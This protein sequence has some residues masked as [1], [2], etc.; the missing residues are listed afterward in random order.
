VLLSLEERERLAGDLL[1]LL[2]GEEVAA[3][4]DGL[5]ADV[6]GV[7][8]PDVEDGEAAGEAGL[9]P[10]GEQGHLERRPAAGLAPSAS[11]SSGKVAR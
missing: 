5:A 2:L 11:M 4:G 6:V 7:V 3:G 8:A 1:G 9:A 10:E